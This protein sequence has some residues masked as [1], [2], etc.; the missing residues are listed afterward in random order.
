MC[1]SAAPQYAQCALP[2]SSQPSAGL[3]TDCFGCFC[4]NDKAY[5]ESPS[6]GVF[7]SVYPY[8][9]TSG[10]R[11][12]FVHVVSLRS[13]GT[14]RMPSNILSDTDLFCILPFYCKV[15]FAIWLPL[16]PIQWSNTDPAKKQT[17]REIGTGQE[18][19]DG[20]RCERRGQVRVTCGRE[21]SSA[22]KKTQCTAHVLYTVQYS[23]ST[24]LHSTTEQ[25]FLWA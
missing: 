6:A 14:T 7:R 3:L 17:C 24:L 22:P 11:H 10:T 16:G 12:H 23:L 15:L 19:A 13:R 18:S 21:S 4:T 9:M 2:P 1:V 8:F 20:R 25:P 5:Q